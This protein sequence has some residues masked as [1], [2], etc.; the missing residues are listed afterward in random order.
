MRVKAEAIL[1]FGVA[2]EQQIEIV[3]EYRDEYKTVSRILD[4][5]PKI[6]DLVHQDLDRLCKSTSRR[7]RKAV[8][9]SENLFR[10]ILVMQREGLDYREASVRI[11]ESETLQSFCRL[12]KKSTIDFTLLSKAFGVI[13]PETWEMINHLLALKGLSDEKVSVDHVRADTTV[14]ECNIHWP[15]DS[16]L[17][18]DCYRVIASTMCAGRELDPKSCPFRFHT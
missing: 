15:T 17:L 8:F 18:W 12:L 13:Q 11:A 16:S 7:G 5:H 10:A 6:L 14:T 9:T 2:D 4:E 3:R 1:E